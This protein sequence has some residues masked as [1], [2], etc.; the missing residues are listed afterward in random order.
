MR[1]LLRRR[2]ARVVGTRQ[3]RSAGRTQSRLGAADRVSRVRGADQRGVHLSRAFG[4]ERAGGDRAS[5]AE[6]RAGAQFRPSRRT[7]GQRGADAD[8][9]RLAPRRI[10]TRAARRRRGVPRAR[11]RAHHRLRR[12]F[13]HAPP[14][15]PR[16]R[17]AL[18]GEA[19]GP[20]RG[21]RDVRDECRSGHAC[22]SRRLMK[23]IVAVVA[24][25]LAI[26]SIARYR[27]DRHERASAEQFLNDFDVADRRPEIASTLPLVPAADLGAN[28][29]ADIALSDA[30]GTVRLADVTPELREKWLRA[31]ERLGVE[32]DTAQGITL[33]ALAARPGWPR[34]WTTLGELVYASQRRSLGA[35]D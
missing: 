10:R 11:T 17:A 26:A 6:R 27:D 16:R 8:H 34:H 13:A 33:D 28:V 14:S 32:L 31:V 19:L 25:A 7:G 15:T 18:G 29:V 20:L 22:R 21:D 30:F 35:A 4:D 12:P 5:G 9:R 3:R 2:G 1:I 24:V 23:R